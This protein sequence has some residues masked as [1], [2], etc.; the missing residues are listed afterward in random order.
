MAKRILRLSRKGIP[1]LSP[2][3]KCIALGI[4]LY[5]GS[6]DAEGHVWDILNFIKGGNVES[7]WVADMSRKYGKATELEME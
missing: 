6:E 5:P 7:T 1:I 3:E 4:T 2:S